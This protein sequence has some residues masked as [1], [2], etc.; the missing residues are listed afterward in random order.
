MGFYFLKETCK[1]CKKKERCDALKLFVNIEELMGTQ[2]ETNMFDI[3]FDIT[4]CR[5]KGE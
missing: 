5:C 3:D 2:N 4:R 1:D